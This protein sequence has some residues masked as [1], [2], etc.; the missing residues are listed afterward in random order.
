MADEFWRYN[1]PAFH[2]YNHSANIP[3]K[4][5]QDFIREVA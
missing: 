2:V 4:I 5:S 1:R 3:I